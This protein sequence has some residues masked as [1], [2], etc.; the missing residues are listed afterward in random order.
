MFIFADN[1]GCLGFQPCMK[2][3]FL[4]VAIVVVLV[5]LVVAVVVLVVVDVVLVV[6]A[7]F[8]V[9]AGLA[10]LVVL[11]VLIVLVV[12]G[13]CGS[14]ALTSD[15]S[16]TNSFATSSVVRCDKILMIVQPVS[17]NWIRRPSESQQAQDPCKIVVK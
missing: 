1:T 3:Q 7:V 14:S 6:L 15:L 5:V 4:V 11:A 13:S 8:G 12:Y 9:L 16:L 17:S 10:V 2:L